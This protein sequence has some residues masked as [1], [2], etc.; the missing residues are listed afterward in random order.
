MSLGNGRSKEAIIMT[1]SA[2]DAEVI[3]R[4][5]TTARDA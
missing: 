3:L 4:S 1:I 2:N 5:R